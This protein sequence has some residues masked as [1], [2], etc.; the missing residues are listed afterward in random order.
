MHAQIKNI[1]DN[2]H[3][4]IKNIGDLYV[5]KFLQ[6]ER[7]TCYLFS[8][9]SL[10]QI[11]FYALHC[12]NY[13]IC[14]VRTLI[15]MEPSSSLLIPWSLSLQLL[16]LFVPPVSHHVIFFPCKFCASKMSANSLSVSKV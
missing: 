11:L 13:S 9:L 2:M 5:L 4:Q 14:T 12:N 6:I 1:E 10:D 7:T 16:V 3:S 15:I 8:N